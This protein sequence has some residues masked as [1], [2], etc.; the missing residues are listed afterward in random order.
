L[1]KAVLTK[2]QMKMKTI[3]ENEWADLAYNGLL[4]EPLIKDIQA[5]NDE[6]Q[7]TCFRKSEDESR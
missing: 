5:F 4:Y 6:N 3:L 2:K 7:K 1:E